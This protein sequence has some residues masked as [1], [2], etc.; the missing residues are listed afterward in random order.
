[1]GVGGREAIL[2]LPREKE[3]ATKGK[4]RRTESGEKC[5]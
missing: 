3:R 5:L 2:S 4:V 1:M